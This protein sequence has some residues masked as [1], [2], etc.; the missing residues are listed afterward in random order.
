MFDKKRINF[1][2][3]CFVF[4]GLTIITLV[5]LW[6]SPKLPKAQMMDGSMRN[7]MKQMHLKDTTIYDLFSS[8]NGQSQTKENMREMHSHH[9][10]QSPVIYKLNYLS[11]AIIFILLPFII[12]GAII[13]SI[14]WIK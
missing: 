3:L 7:M 9:Q 5:L 8:E 12:G 14:V 2:R 10:G 6:S 11:T 4:S 1:W 13:L